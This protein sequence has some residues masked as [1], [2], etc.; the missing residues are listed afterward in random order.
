MS[1]EKRLD[2]DTFPSKRH[3][4]ERSTQS[5]TYTHIHT[6]TQTLPQTRCLD[7]SSI[8][9]QSCFGHVFVISRPYCVLQRRIF[10]TLNQGQGHKCIDTDTVQ[11]E[12]FLYFELLSPYCRNKTKQILQ[13]RQ[14]RYNVI[15]MLHRLHKQTIYI[16]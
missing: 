10:C 3:S 12:C 16:E 14:K 1:R 7:L 2:F 13:R 5:H 6:H 8:Y 15:L 9:A 11:R 4:K